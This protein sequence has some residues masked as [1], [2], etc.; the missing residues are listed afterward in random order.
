M[1]HDDTRTME[2]IL[3]FGAGNIGRSFI[4]QIFGRNGYGVVFVDVDRTLVNMLSREGRYDVV[5]RFPDGREERLT[6]PGVSAVEGTDRQ[7]VQKTLEQVRLVATSVGAAVLPRL[8][9]VLTADALRRGRTGEMPFDLILAENTHTGGHLV[10]TTFAD[11]FQ[12][13]GISDRFLPGVVE[14]SVGKMVPI[15][16]ADLRRREPT[17]V[18]AEGFNTLVVDADGWTGPLPSVP[19]LRPV[20]PIAAWVD[21]K[22]YIHNLGHAAC[23]YLG[24]RA[25]PEATFIW[26]VLEDT[27]IAA[28]VKSA[29]TATAEALRR[30]YPGV[31]TSEDLEGH[32]GDLLY[33]FSSKSLGD[34]VFRVGRDLRRKLAPQDRVV[35]ALRLLQKHGMDPEPIQQIYRGALHFRAV[36]EGGNPFPPDRE[37][38]ASLAVARDPARMVAELSG[39]RWPEER[40]LVE[41]I[42]QDAGLQHDSLYPQ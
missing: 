40:Q 15:I 33:R 13:A 25:R 17:T 37:L 34:T 10:R 7:A 16:P 21:R 1:M 6:V 39:F 29:M 12:S 8:I 28:E 2:K 42:I 20:R 19:Q 14:C 24:Y 38:L 32:I 23:A 22:L 11:A 26:Q 35:G 41:S 31:F 3:I 5:H 9:P 27:A 4:G 36:D 30:E 18:W